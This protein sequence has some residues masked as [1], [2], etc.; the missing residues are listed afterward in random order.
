MK[1]KNVKHTL[2]IEKSKME[3]KN[4]NSDTF[5]LQIYKSQW[6]IAI[7]FICLLLFTKNAEYILLLNK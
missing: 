7:M 5:N 2:Y 4:N 1:E 6:N 3:K